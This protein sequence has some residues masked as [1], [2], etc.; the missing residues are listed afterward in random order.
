MTKF[1]KVRI[2]L[3]HLAAGSRMRARV[4]GNDKAQTPLKV[5]VKIEPIPCAVG[6]NNMLDSLTVAITLPDAVAEPSVSL[7]TS[8]FAAGQ[9]ALRMGKK[10]LM[11]AGLSQAELDGIGIANVV[12]ETT[13]ITYLVPV[14]S[15]GRTQPLMH[16]IHQHG[17]LLGLRIT[18]QPKLNRTTYRT[19]GS[20]SADTLAGAALVL[21]WRAAQCHVCLHVALDTV[22]LERQG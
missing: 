21:D 15:S 17:L 19:D 8:V 6:G 3:K 5:G 13:A 4:F 2:N 20:D 16:G 18:S 9:I 11:H 1:I 14:S 22:Y 12:L 10:W 7:G